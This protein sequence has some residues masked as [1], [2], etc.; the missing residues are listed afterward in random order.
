MISVCSSTH[1]LSP[2]GCGLFTHC[3]ISLHS[4][5]F[6]VCN[7]PFH[8]LINLCSWEQLWEGN[9]IYS[10]VDILSFAAVSNECWLQCTY[11]CCTQAM[12]YKQE[13]NCDSLVP[14]DHRDR[15]PRSERLAIWLL[16]P[17]PLQ[18]AV[19]TPQS[20]GNSAVKSWDYLAVSP[21]TE[22]PPPPSPFA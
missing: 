16:L 20:L 6:T 7:V 14:E 3:T 11:T 15:S 1:A 9:D 4:G 19:P 5:N 17:V 22:F 21:C 18:V 10:L 12:N 2:S 8:L 13:I